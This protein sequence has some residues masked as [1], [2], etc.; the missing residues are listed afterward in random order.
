MKC[1]GGF[2]QVHDL[3]MTKRAWKSLLEEMGENEEAQ[4]LEYVQTKELGGDGLVLAYLKTVN[5][6]LVPATGTDMLIEDM[7]TSFTKYASLAKK[8]TLTEMMNALLPEIF[9]VLYSPLERETKFPGITAE[10]IMKATGLHE[11]IRG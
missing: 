4:A 10:M 1:L 7:D 8:V 11:K 9:T 5:D 2:S 3:T 6:E